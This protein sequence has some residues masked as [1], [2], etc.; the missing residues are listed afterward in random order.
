MTTIMQ[1]LWENPMGTDGFEFVEYAAPDP[2]AL[3]TVFERMGF[4]AIAR[5]RS[6]QV[7]LYRQGD[8][9]FLINAE[10]ESFAQSFA[11]VHGPSIC[12][13]GFRVK[14]AAQAYARAKELGAKPVQGKVGPMELNIPAIEGIGGSLIYLVD[15][16]GEKG[17]IYDVDFVPLPGVGQAPAGAG[18]SYID[19]LTHNVHKG[20]MDVW[21]GFY[22]KLFNFR[23]IRYF[24]IEGKLT[25]VKSR[26]MTSPDG[27]IRIP[28]NE[29]GGAV[30]GRVDQIEEYLQAY[31]GEGIQHI[32]LGTNDIHRTVEALRGR[33]V[34]FLDTPDTY[35]DLIDKR[36]PGHGEDVEHLRRNGILLDGGPD[37]GLLLQIF[38]ETV[39]GPI[40]YEIIQ[41][42]GDDG[43]GEGNFKALFESIELDQIQRGVLTA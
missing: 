14:D 42:K 40:F 21:A 26:A 38:T 22:E 33:N 25:G 4:T 28:I 35:Y 7:T 24:D 1:D 10:P 41:R 29:S 31:K 36:L 43:F 34:T 12:A 9:N 8:V 3:A 30:P 16:Y 11:R 19:H 27:K 39:I 13:M 18:L 5:H 23:Q 6:K 2:A 32:A 17:S 15:R 37:G 20:R